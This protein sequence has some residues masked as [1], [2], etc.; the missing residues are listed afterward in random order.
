MFDKQI[1][2]KQTKEVMLREINKQT[3][4]VSHAVGDKQTNK[5]SKSCCGEKQ[6]SNQSRSCYVEINR[7]LGQRINV[8]QIYKQTNKVGPAVA[9]SMFTN[10]QINKQSRSCM[11]YK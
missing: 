9:G 1:K 7:R 4:K 8:Y 3:N 10:K 2:N 11:E 6:T 5:K